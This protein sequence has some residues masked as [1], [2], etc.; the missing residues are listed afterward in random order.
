MRF[1]RLLRRRLR[2]PQKKLRLHSSREDDE[3]TCVNNPFNVSSAQSGTL[4]SCSFIKL[5][6]IEATQSGRLLREED[7]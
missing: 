5:E 7:F 6:N 2:S 3:A 1:M 4:R